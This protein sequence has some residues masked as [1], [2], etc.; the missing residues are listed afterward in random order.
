[1]TPQRA[2]PTTHPDY[3]AYR[4]PL[5]QVYDM[6]Y[7]GRGKDFASEAR[8][9]ADL[10]R[11]RK[12]DAAS[13]LDAGC[14]TGEHLATWRSIFAHVEGVDI[15]PDMIAVARAKL[16]G[17]PIHLGDIRDFDLGRTVDS[18]ST[19]FSTLG[20]MPSKADLDAAVANLARHLPLGGVLVAEPWWFPDKFLDG[21][22][23]HDVV[24]KD[25]TTLARVV[26]TTTV[27]G[28]AHLEAHYIAADGQG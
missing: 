7:L 26:R 11:T 2:R 1:M 9:V 17:V 21:H 10:I 12:P 28:T 27:D 20:Y 8:V 16:P 18:I 14:G 23:G 25:G 3:S 15:S 13:L 19:L 24:Q 4:A 6:I 5:S 22:I